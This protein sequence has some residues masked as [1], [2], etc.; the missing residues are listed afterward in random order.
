VPTP[1]PTQDWSSVQAQRWLRLAE[2]LRRRL[3]HGVAL[4]PVMRPVFEGR[5]GT[6]L[7]AALVHRGRFAGD[8]AQA[9]GAQALAVDEHIVGASEALDA[10]TPGGA[11]LLGHELTHV[12]QRSLGDHGEDAARAVEQAFA[13]AA[14]RT[15]APIDVEQLADRVYRRLVDEL[16]DDRERAAWVH[17][18]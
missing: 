17:G 2:E 16:R 1:D 5:L 9:V 3:G 10:A 8:L 11:A 12:V 15:A 14:T 4:D 6:N 13:Q 18:A 7:S